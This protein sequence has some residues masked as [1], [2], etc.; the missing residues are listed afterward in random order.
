LRGLIGVPDPEFEVVEVENGQE[1]RRDVR[2][3]GW[4]RQGHG[5][6]LLRVESGQQREANPILSG[7][8]HG[9]VAERETARTPASRLDSLASYRKGLATVARVV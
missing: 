2:I 3:G 7:S 1:V 5:G 9:S 4:R 6:H 8:G